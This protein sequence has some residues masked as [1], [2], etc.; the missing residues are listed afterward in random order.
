MSNG[1][2]ELRRS[3]LRFL[4]VMKSEL[5]EPSLCFAGGVKVFAPACASATVCFK[6]EAE[7][8]LWH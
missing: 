6:F 3:V 7:A 5:H 4:K 2:P 8:E 1:V